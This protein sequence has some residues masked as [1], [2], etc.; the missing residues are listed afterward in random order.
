MDG[1][2]A[3]GAAMSQNGHRMDDEGV[4]LSCYPPYSPALLAKNRQPKPDPVFR[5]GT[6]T[7]YL[8][9]VLQKLVFS[10]GSSVRP[11]FDCSG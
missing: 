10:L 4:V 2:T 3:P 6:T 8:V 1:A 5:K 7:G 11:P 9:P